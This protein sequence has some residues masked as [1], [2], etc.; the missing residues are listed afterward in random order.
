MNFKFSTVAFFSFLFLF[1]QTNQ[2]GSIKAQSSSDH[3]FAV[4]DKSSKHLALS[5]TNC[6]DDAILVFDGS[7]SMANAGY[8]EKTPRIFE[9][10][11]AMRKV[12]PQVT[13]FRKL[14]LIIFGPGSQQSCQ[15][16]D[17][18]LMPAL[19][20][21]SKII[22]ELEKMRPSGKTPITQAVQ[23]AASVL[24]YRTQPAVVV[25]VTDGDETCGGDPCRL[26]MDLLKEAKAITIHVIGF[27][28]RYKHYEFPFDKSEMR[29][30]TKAQCLAQS[31]GGKFF[32][33]ETTEELEAALKETL[34]CPLLTK[35]FDASQISSR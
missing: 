33:A 23:D 15:N 19:G 6:T 1:L 4:Q 17:Y 11:K 29:V 9:A 13:N 10:R 34:G 3:P 7:S 16:V 12:L 14:G 32:S 8:L 5:D 30:H 2:V 31:T 28:A 22:S 20:N 27:K 25:L 35:A 24:E 26:A 21:A 18:R